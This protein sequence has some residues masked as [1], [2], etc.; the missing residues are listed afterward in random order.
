MHGSLPPYRYEQREIT[1]AIADLCEVQGA[2]RRVL[3]HVH[4][5]AQVNTRYTAL[6]LEK[7][8][9]LTDFGATN[10]AYIRAAVDLGAEAVSEALRAAAL[11]PVDVDMVMFT[12][13]TGVAAPSID[14]RIAARLGFRPDVKRLPVFGLGCAGGAAGLART[15]DYLR[16]WPDQVAVL[17]SVELCSLTLQREDRSV[18]SM[19]ANG[20][21]GDGAAAVVALGS[22]RGKG[23]PGPSVVA[24]RSLL[25][26]DTERMLGWD[27]DQNGFRVVLGADLPAV[28]RQ[29]LG[30]DV[31][32]FLADNG[33]AVDDVAAWVSHT[34]GPK[35]LQAVESTLDLKDGALD[36]A[37]RSLASVGNLS[38][39]SVL[40]VLRDT[41][42]FRPPPHGSPGLLFAFGPGLCSELVL[43]RW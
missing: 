12:T 8:A 36:L 40:H 16:A 11:T 33:L 4:Q 9:D 24:T 32:A 27:V 25:Y 20:L 3:E 15:H 41:L 19:V 17:L 18:P 29:R 2:G 26:P 6:P 42:A 7:Y 43:L 22:E 30:D 31:R 5:S 14:A 28:V 13:V 38:S 34:G 35:I 23:V 1:E 10:D 37:W 21:F 39:A